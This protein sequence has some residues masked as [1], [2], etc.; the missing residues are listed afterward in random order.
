[1]LAEYMRQSP[2]PANRASISVRNMLAC[3]HINTMTEPNYQ[4]EI[5]VAVRLAR[6]AGAILLKHYHS[7]FLVEHKVENFLSK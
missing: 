1:M 6:V 2:W 7:P 3:N 5:Q 4:R